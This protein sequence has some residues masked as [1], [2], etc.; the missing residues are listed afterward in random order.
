W[1]LVCIQ[2]PEYGG[3]EIYFDDGLIRKDGRFVVPELEA[4]IPENLK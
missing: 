1:D 4:L 3:G 2:R